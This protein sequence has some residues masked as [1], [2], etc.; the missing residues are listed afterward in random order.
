MKKLTILIVTASIL[1]LTIN[2]FIAPA[3]AKNPPVQYFQITSNPAYDRNPSIIQGQDG[4]YWLFFAQSKSGSIRGIDGF[5]PD[6]AS[7]K[8]CYKKS[9][10]IA[11]LQKAPENIIP[12]SDTFSDNA[13]RDV[14]ALH[15]GDGKIWVF[16]SSGYT[17]SNDNRIFYY[18]Y[19]HGHWSGPTPIDN[20]SVA[21]HINAVEY[22]GQIWLFFDV[23][24]Y[25]LE[26]IHWNGKIWSSPVVISE[27]ASIAKAM[28]D[29]GKL[30]VVWSYVVNNVEYGTY[31]GLSTSNDGKTWNNHGKIISWPE[32][33]ATN[34]DPV[35]VKDKGLFR[36]FWAP[37]VGSGGQFIATSTSANP[38]GMWSTPVKL[39]SSNYNGNS[40]WNF[41]PCP[42]IQ[43]S[44]Y[45]FYTSESN[46]YGTAM[47]D[48]NIW[49]TRIDK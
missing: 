36:I 27:N 12:V 31:I 48:G 46:S 26:G 24:P 7:Y 41:W 40:W 35:L 11:G 44:I 29:K 43:N 10:T 1:L 34:W 42:F 16:T 14:V 21:G 13:Q 25:V 19:N 3:I 20:T 8:I 23:W 18:Q 15:D 4:N 33:G 17:Y 38:T 2:L 45:V 49:M 28:V 6:A 30:F 47:I 32:T 9:K 22:K 37:D 39:T 5:D